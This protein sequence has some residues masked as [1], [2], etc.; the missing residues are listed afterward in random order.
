MRIWHRGE[1]RQSGEHRA[2]EQRARVLLVLTFVVG[3]LGI[4]TSRRWTDGLESDLAYALGEA[5]VVAGFLG[6]TVDIFFKREL[7]RDAFEAGLGYLLPEAMRPEVRWIV[8][9][10][11]LCVDYDQHFTLSRQGADLRLDIDL[12]RTV[13]NVGPKKYEYRPSVV[14]DEW[15]LGTPSDIDALEILPVIGSEPI[16]SL[17]AAPEGCK[18]EGVAVRAALKPIVLDPGEEI[19]V[20]WSAHEIKPSNGSYNQTVMIPVCC[21]VI[22]VDTCSDIDASVTFGNRGEWSHVGRR[23]LLSTTLLPHQVIALR[24]W[25]RSKVD[26]SAPPPPAVL[27]P[28]MLNGV[29]SQYTGT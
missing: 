21:P 25:E 14:V 12:L 28:D 17:A 29:V 9:Q 16:A 10:E 13:K 6:L 23:W 11:L 5:L 24:W 7:V 4:F 1:R 20:H 27:A 2:N 18:R 19:R 3:L 26:P 22:N 8:G 15:F